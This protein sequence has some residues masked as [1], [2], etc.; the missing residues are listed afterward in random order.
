MALMVTASLSSRFRPP[1][2]RPPYEFSLVEGFSLITPPEPPDPL[3]AV[4]LF[5]PLQILNA[6]VKP[7]LQEFTQTFILMLACPTMV[8]KL[9]GG[10][11]P[12]VSAG[13]IPFAYG[14]LFPVV[15]MS[16]CRGADW[17]SLRSNLGLPLPPLRTVL[18]VHICL[19][20]SDYLYS[21]EGV[22]MKVVWNTLDMWSLLLVDDVLMDRLSFSSTL[23]RSL[24][25]LEGKFIGMFHLVN[26]L[27]MDT[28]FWIVSCFEQ[29]LF[30][31]FP[32]VWMN[33]KLMFL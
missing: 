1:P 26:I 10:G 29:F 25:A 12:F 31:I 9:N 20:L 5:A 24:P 8:T 2:D 33:W 19:S 17:S 7:S 22:G 30:L 32:F 14:H 6:S 13:D 11:A 15:Y 4:Y 27:L 16:H 23:V 28:N 21:V 3:D 18:Q